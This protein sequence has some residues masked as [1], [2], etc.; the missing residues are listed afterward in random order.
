MRVLLLLLACC[1]CFAD[2][3]SVVGATPD[4][5]V[6]AAPLI[7]AAVCKNG[8]ALVAVVNGGTTDDD[9]DDDWLET[10]HG[11]VRISQIDSQGT[12]LLCAGWR[13]DADWLASKCRSLAAADTMQT[14]HPDDVSLWM[15]YCA[16]SGGV[17]A[18]SVVGLLTIDKQLYLIDSTGAYAVRAHAVGRGSKAV[19]ARLRTLSLQ[20]VT[21]EQGVKDICRLLTTKGDDDNDWE[22]LSNTTRVELAIVDDETSKLQRIRQPFLVAKRTS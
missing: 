2:E 12:A 21:A 3:K 10:Y 4:P 19:N 8:V 16:A 22:P 7:V 9:D 15:A 17:R 5:W 11:P 13:P 20:D 6:S 1:T 14:L 18:L